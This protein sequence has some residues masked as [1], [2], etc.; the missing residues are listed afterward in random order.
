MAMRRAHHATETEYDGDPMHT[1]VSIDNDAGEQE[2]LLQ[3]SAAAA[4]LKQPE[5]ENMCQNLLNSTGLYRVEAALRWVWLGI[6]LLMHYIVCRTLIFPFYDDGS[7]LLGHTMTPRSAT[8]LH[9][10]L[11]CWTCL[12]LVVTP[13]PFAK[14]AYDFSS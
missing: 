7:S 12:G 1:A 14:C 8:P 9:L 6:A 2:R 10:W 11:V 4:E 3:G 5:M 13:C